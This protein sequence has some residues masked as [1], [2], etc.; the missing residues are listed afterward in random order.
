MADKSR[1]LFIGRLTGNQALSPISI[2]K[3]PLPS[4]PTLVMKAMIKRDIDER[5]SKL[6]FVEESGGD[7]WIMIDNKFQVKN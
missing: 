6:Q 3:K 7:Q 1:D 5:K 4:Q 2:Q